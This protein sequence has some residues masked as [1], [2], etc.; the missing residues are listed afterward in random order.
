MT[1]NWTVDT[2]PDIGRCMMERVWNIWKCYLLG[3]GMQGGTIV[4]WLHRKIVKEP[5]VAVQHRPETKIN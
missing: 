1:S 4:K 3:E 5:A 2:A